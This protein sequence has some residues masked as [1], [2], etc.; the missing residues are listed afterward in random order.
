[1]IQKLYPLGLQFTHRLRLEGNEFRRS[2]RNCLRFYY[3]MNGFHCGQLAV[4]NRMN[5][6]NRVMRWKMEGDQGRDWQ[7]AAVDLDMN[8]VTEVILHI[9][10]AFSHRKLIKHKVTNRV[11]PICPELTQTNPEMYLAE[12]VLISTDLW[13]TGTITI[14]L[15]NFSHAVYHE[16]YFSANKHRIYNFLLYLS[17]Q[18]QNLK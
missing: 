4:Y 18:T 3:S 13:F 5:N 2:G 9:H 6:G 1:M 11:Y 8:S 17:K 12:C 14:T 15:V 7:R 10:F 16:H